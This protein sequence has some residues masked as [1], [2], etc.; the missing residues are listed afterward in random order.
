MSIRKAALVCALALTAGCSSKAAREVHLFTWDNYDDPAV[1]AEFER[2]TGI[3]VVVDRFASNEELL[4]K[5][6]EGDRVVSMEMI[7]ENATVLTV[8]E[9]GFGKRTEFAEYRGQGRGGS[10]LINIKIT[11]KNGPVA[12]IVKV[13]DTDEL[14]ISTSAGK[15]IRIAM[16]DVHVIGRNTQ[17]V[18]LMDIEKDEHITGIAPIAEKEDDGEAEEE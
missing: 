13:V 4:A 2:N 16:K 5:L 15:I 9:H 14:M 17:G 11:D 18:K 7:E 1:F 3:R 12:G 8:T 6:D 10:G